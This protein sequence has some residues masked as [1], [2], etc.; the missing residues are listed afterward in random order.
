MCSDAGM[1]NKTA[2]V[3]G[4]PSFPVV[5]LFSAHPHMLTSL[6]LL[7]GDVVLTRGGANHKTCRAANFYPISRDT[8]D[9]CGFLRAAATERSPFVKVITFSYLLILSTDISTY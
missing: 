8:I 7:L 9:A 2:S 3:C 4:F 5:Q 6:C 1:Q